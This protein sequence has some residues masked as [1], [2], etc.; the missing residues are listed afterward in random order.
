M[1]ARKAAVT[2]LLGLALA[3]WVGLVV[4]RA[5]AGGLV[6]AGALGLLA[7]ALGVARPWRAP[8]TL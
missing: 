5:P 4:F 7:L 8:A 1:A 2:A 3:G 6:L